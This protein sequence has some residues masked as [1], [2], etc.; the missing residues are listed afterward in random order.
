MPLEIKKKITTQ[1]FPEITIGGPGIRVAGIVQNFEEGTGPYGDYKKFS[2]E[3]AAKMG[4]RTVRAGVMYLPS[5]AADLIAADVVRCASTPG[6]SGLE[7]ALELVK[8]SDE[9]PKNGR[10]YQ[11][12]VVPLIEPTTTTSRA[13]AL[14]DGPKADEIKPDEPK[15]G[16]GKADDGKTPKA[17]K[18]GA[19]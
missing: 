16:D 1:L 14:L 18:A 10:G 4:D 15:D 13:L 12:S 5:I 19:K 9:D 6:F 3:F 17:G 11:W 8:S 2:G 7:F